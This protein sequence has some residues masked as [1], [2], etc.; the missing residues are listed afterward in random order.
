M[1]LDGK[2]MMILNI[3]NCEGGSPAQIVAVA[4]A[5]GLTNVIIKVADAAN[6]HNVDH[7]TKVDLAPPLVA[8]LKAAGLEVWGWHYIYGFNPADEANTAVRRVK[9]LDLSGYIVNAESE[10]KLPGRAQNAKTF[11]DILREGLSIPIAFAS[12]R[13]PSF[14]PQLPW[15]VF[16]ESCYL[17]MPQVYW[18]NADNP[19]AQL[20]RSVREYN[21]IHPRPLG[22]T[23]P[24][25]KSG[26][27]S[28]KPEELISFMDTAKQLSC[29]SV[30]FSAWDHGRTVLTPLWEAVSNYAWD[31]KK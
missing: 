3:R 10:Y 12:Y 21:A 28:A 4:K 31:L 9:D 19:A 27:W 1:A 7:N 6:L 15:N 11:M 8:A 29:K 30:N 20:Q 26:A 17:A 13:F 25:F 23:G 14:H 5:A 16:M 18:E 2:G 22:P 24:I